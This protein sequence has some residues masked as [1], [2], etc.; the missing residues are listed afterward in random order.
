MLVADPR[1]SR[2]VFARSAGVSPAV[3]RRRRENRRWAAAF[4]EAVWRRYGVVGP[5]RDVR[6]LALAT[7][8]G[9]FELIIDWLFDEAEDATELIER[10]MAYHR[11]VRAGL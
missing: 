2:V 4:V 9:L 5:D 8:G 3:E 6:H 1:V 10:L 7:V 11:V